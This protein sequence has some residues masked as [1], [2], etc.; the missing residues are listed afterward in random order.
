MKISVVMAACNGAKFI[1]EQ[2]FSILPQLDLEDELI[3]SLDPS[4]DATEGIIQSITDPKIRVISG[5]GK[6]VMKN[7][8]NALEHATGD[9][10]FLSDQDDVW[11][12]DK[13]AKVK[14]EFELHPETELLVHDCIITDKKLNPV[15]SSY[16]AFHGSKP[17]A[18]TN[19]LRNS[20]IGCCMAFRRSLLERT[21]P[22]P[23]AVPMHDQWLGVAASLTGKVVFLPD[24]LLLYRRHEKNQS[25]LSHAGIRQMLAWRLN[26]L[27]SLR[28]RGL[29]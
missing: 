9:V 11:L 21:L 27:L 15:H 8:E 23:E 22:F 10:V 28:N 26:L 17:G 3:I 18:V 13:V 4:I 19:I 20:F 25:S 16:F 6:G 1:D 12:P 7:F 5:P 24:Q 29:L 2:I 14:S